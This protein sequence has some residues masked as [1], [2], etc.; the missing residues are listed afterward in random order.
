MGEPAGLWDV[1]D[2]ADLDKSAPKCQA[3]PEPVLGSP[4]SVCGLVQ[5]RICVFEAIGRR[6][7]VDLLYVLLRVCLQ[8]FGPYSVQQQNT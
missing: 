1:V 3:S 8:T 5:G 2:K 6:C 4:G 7:V